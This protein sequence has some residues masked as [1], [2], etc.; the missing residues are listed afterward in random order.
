LHL[1]RWSSSRRGLAWLEW[2]LIV[3]AQLFARLCSHDCVR[4]TVFAHLRP[5]AA[6]SQVMVSFGMSLQ[7][8]LK[9]QRDELRLTRPWLRALVAHRKRVLQLFTEWDENGDGLVDKGEF[10]RGVLRLG[11]DAV[12]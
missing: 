10:R 5:H 4:T 12:G 6:P 7:K 1:P 3:F 2:T 8:W 11:F 9:E